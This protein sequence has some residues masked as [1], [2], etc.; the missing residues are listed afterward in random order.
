MTPPRSAA[1]GPSPAATAEPRLRV[2][3][4]RISFPGADRPAVDGVSFTL[5]A[6]GALGLVGASG[7]GKTLTLGAIVGLPPPA[8]RVTGRVRYDGAEL[9]GAPPATLRRIRGRRIG[10]VFQEPLAALA[11]FLPVGIQIAD[12]ARHHRGLSRAAAADRARELLRAVELPDPADRFHRY[13][14]ELSGGQRQRAAIAVALA[15]DPELL[16][17][18]EP[19]TALDPTVEAGVLALLVRLRDERGLA[20]LLVGHRFELVTSVC[21]RLAVM[22]AGRI[23]ESGPAAA[24]AGAPGHPYTAALVAAAPG[25][26]RPRAALDAAELA[27]APLPGCPFRAVCPRATESCGR[28]VP[29]VADAGEGRAI[30]CVHPLAP[31]EAA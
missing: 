22:A 4:L 25:R 23:V 26:R 28:P 10:F 16:L 15:G 18:D 6:G 29:L 17:A 21:D 9:L 7:S 13:P 8:A 30:A 11:P 1:P 24:I 27:P 2:E 31:G 5:P 12:V 14:H 19:T 20:L 3:D